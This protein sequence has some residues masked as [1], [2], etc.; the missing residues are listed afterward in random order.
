MPPSANGSNGHASNGHASN[1]HN[2]SVSAATK[3][4]R[5]IEDPQGFVVGPGVYDGLSARIALE[6]GFDVLY[7]VWSPP[8]PD[9]DGHGI[10]MLTLTIYTDRSWH[11]SIPPR[12][13]RHWPRRAQRHESP[14]RDDCKP[15]PRGTSH[16]RHGHR[17]R[18]YVSAPFP[19]SKAVFCPGWNT[20]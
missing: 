20:K 13:A 14:S 12:P 6:S 7:M 11:S 10:F 2:V 5:M 8:A 1:G 15:K 4:R 3:L 9:E 18:R 16:C 17:L 19:N